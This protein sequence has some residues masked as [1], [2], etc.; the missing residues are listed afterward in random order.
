MVIIDAFSIEC[1]LCAVVDLMRYYAY[2]DYLK[3]KYG[4]KVY[5]IPVNIPATCPNR[6]GVKGVNGCIFCGEKGTGF[7]NLSNTLSVKEQLEKNIAY[8]GKKYHAHK[9][10]AYFQNFTNTYVPLINLPD[11]TKAAAKFDDVVEICYSTRPDCI[12]DKYLNSIASISQSSNKEVCIELGLQTVNYHTLKVL[13]RGHSLAEFIDAV[14]RIKKYGFSTC[15]HLILNLPWDSIEDVVETAKVVSA[16][17]IEQVKL[18]SLYVEK[19]TEL[20]KMYVA[21]ELRIISLEEYVDRVIL[22]LEY[23]A[24]DIVVQ[25]LIGRAPEEDTV[26]CNWGTSWWKIK[27]RIEEKME[28][29]ETFQGKRFDY[30]NGAALNKFKE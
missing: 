6:D 27:E 23:L 9:F 21:Q 10:I 20:C 19:N 11:Y 15:A 17:G 25:R 1:I 18:H 22:F 13:N 2:S 4:E 24:P 30:L 3:E 28:E 26:F 12:S 5:K 16:L 8:I 29:M 7:E 14:L